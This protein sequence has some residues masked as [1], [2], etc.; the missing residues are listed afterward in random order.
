MISLK[1]DDSRHIQLR[2]IYEIEWATHLGLLRLL[3]NCAIDVLGISISL[4][5]ASEVTVE[6][7]DIGF[8][9]NQQRL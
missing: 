3:G 7:S 1:L 6:V 8:Y 5:L 4:D 9:L 2:N